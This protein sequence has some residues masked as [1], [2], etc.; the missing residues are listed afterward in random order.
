MGTC[1]LTGRSA[2]LVDAKIALGRFGGDIPAL[3]LPLD[4]VNR[5]VRAVG[6]AN[7]A[8]DA[9]DRIDDDFAAG[10]IAVNRPR[11]TANHAHWIGAMQTGV[12]H[13]YILFDW[14]LA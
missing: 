11:R 4:H 3:V 1:A 7:L 13:H 8:A 9:S 2:V 14:S 12:D 6:G 5:I 10:S